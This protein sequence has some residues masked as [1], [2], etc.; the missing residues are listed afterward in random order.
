[1]EGQINQYC[2][3]PRLDWLNPAIGSCKMRFDTRV[4]FSGGNMRDLASLASNI[5][6]SITTSCNKH[7]KVQYFLQTIIMNWSNNFWQ[8]RASKALGAGAASYMKYCTYYRQTCIELYNLEFEC[9]CRV[10]TSKHGQKFLILLKSVLFVVFSLIRRYP[11]PTW[12][13]SNWFK[14]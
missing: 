5:G 10:I 14:D 7:K 9:I 2:K 8:V 13:E 6:W 11:D 12:D 3:S 4:P 1:M